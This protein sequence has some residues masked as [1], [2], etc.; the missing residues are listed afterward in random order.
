MGLNKKINAFGVSI[1]NISLQDVYDWVDDQIIKEK[2]GY[3]VTPNVDHVV[4]L[5]KDE[6]FRNIYKGASLVLND[7][8]ILK[9]SGKLL[10]HKMADKISG[11][12]L[13]PLMCEHAVKK[14]YSLYF[15]GG[16][17]GVAEKAKEKLS[18]QYPGLRVVG[19][20]S[21][22]FGF[23][24]DTDEIETIIS[25]INAQD[26]DI[27]FIGLGAPKQERFAHDYR[28]VLNVNATFCTGAAFD[29]EA[30]HI[31]RAPKWMQKMGLEWFYRFL[32]EPKRMFKR[33]FLDDSKFFI[34]FV[35]A[36]FSKKK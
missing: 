7:S 21:P 5:S 25:N 28:D 23:E 15:L 3:V 14:N 1:D 27:M 29:F 10:G 16:M 30:G 12:D 34:I 18:N 17:P 19:T 35:K 4:K 13:L 33:Y 32:K 24:K 2:K 36:F 11:S 6:G 31:N 9:R 8:V 22:P 20:Y 26:V